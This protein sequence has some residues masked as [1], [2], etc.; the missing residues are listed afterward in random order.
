MIANY[1]TRGK[2][3]SLLL[4]ACVT[5]TSL[6]AQNDYKSGYFIDNDGTRTDVSIL[7]MDWARNPED[8]TYMIAGRAEPRKG[9]IVDVREFKVGDN[10]FERFQVKMDVSS[11]DINSLS[12]NNE[13]EWE[14][15]TVFLK[16][17]VEGKARL[18]H[19]RSA[20]LELFFFS[21]GNSKVEQLVYRKVSVRPAGFAE[22]NQY[23]N[24]LMAQVSCG[25]SIPEENMPG[26][27]LS[28]LQEYF[29]RFNGCNG[30]TVA[31]KDSSRSSSSNFSIGISAGWDFA[32]YRYKDLA[33]P[34]PLGDDSDPGYQVGVAA[35]FTLP[36]NNRKWSILAQPT[37]QASAGS[38]PDRH[39]QSV[40]IPVGVRHYFFLK[41]VD[42]FLDG[43]AVLDVP[44]RYEATKFSAPL[45]DAEVTSGIAICAAIGGGVRW[46]Q[47]SLEGRYYLQRSYTDY[48][49]AQYSKM[50]VIL[51]YSFA[52]LF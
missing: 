11:Q 2:R 52:R 46:K 49:V 36:F 35:E 22:N 40:E 21:V 7:D 50:S 14:T 3:A 5:A 34:S 37:Y 44:I 17:I 27:T 10:K 19:Y 47:L 24:Q 29:E 1:T 12:E 31:K 41:S 30:R 13:P 32:T 42:L 4:I 45:P 26:Y 51:G 16:Q 39:H 9:R 25:E 23:K 28:A 43:L 6:L 48:Y 20:E 15:R 8:F 18:Y 33:V 38:N